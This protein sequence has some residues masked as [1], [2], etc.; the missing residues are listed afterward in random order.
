VIYEGRKRNK[1]RNLRKCGTVC[2]RR[3][4]DKMNR[5]EE[6]E[7]EILMRKRQRYKSRIS[8]KIERKF[9]E[10]SK[11]YTM[12]IKIEEED[13][14]K[15]LRKCGTVCPRRILENNRERRNLDIQ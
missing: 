6:K 10:G 14:R 4:L 9:S 2:P 8:E 3:I 5:G 13:G 15:N 7:K 12:I 11:I 1:K